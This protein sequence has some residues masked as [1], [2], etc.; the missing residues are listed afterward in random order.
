MASEDSVVPR[1]YDEPAYDTFSLGYI[2]ARPHRARAQ[3]C[4]CRIYAARDLCSLAASVTM[5]LTSVAIRWLSCLRE[6]H[7]GTSA[8][9]IS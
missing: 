2:R 3:V 5:K 9:M 7:L 1:L 4:T 6:C 8:G